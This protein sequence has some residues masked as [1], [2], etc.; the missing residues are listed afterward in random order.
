MSGCV[1]HVDP[2]WHVERAIETLTLHPAHLKEQLAQGWRMGLRLSPIDR[3]A[4]MRF[5]E[6]L[7]VLGWPAGTVLSRKLVFRWAV[8]CALQEAQDEFMGASC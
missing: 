5:A 4:F 7:H 2:F 3:P 1:I 8:S 6:R